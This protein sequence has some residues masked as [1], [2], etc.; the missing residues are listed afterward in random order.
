MLTFDTT[1]V[2][3]GTSILNPLPT[4]TAI[5][6]VLVVPNWNIT[7]FCA[8]VLTLLPLNTTSFTP[9][10]VIVNPIPTT[11]STAFVAWLSASPVVVIPV[12][13]LV[14]IPILPFTASCNVNVVT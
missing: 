11:P 5:P 14:V 10:S 7:S 9:I 13:L 2:F 3:G 8:T 1:T 12:I 6:V 4:V